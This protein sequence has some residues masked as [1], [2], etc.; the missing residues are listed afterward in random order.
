M[1]G[2][3]RINIRVC[4]HT[5]NT[6]VIKSTKMFTPL[7]VLSKKPLNIIWCI[8]ILHI[9]KITS[10]I[11]T[12]FKLFSLVFSQYNS[13]FILLKRFSKGSQN[14]LNC[15]LRRAIP[16]RI[17][18]PLNILY[19]ILSRTGSPKSTSSPHQVTL[20]CLSLS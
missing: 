5:M 6:Q 9:F 1:L 11:Q 7:I 14:L 13:V 10:V 15:Q 12:V 18:C 20:S 17:I 3:E 16:H 8:K 4:T 19:K 2:E